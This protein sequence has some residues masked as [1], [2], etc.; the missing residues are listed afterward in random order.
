MMV[1][2]LGGGMVSFS[3]AVVICIVPDFVD[4]DMVMVVY[5]V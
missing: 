4:D 1:T 2:T 5:E 3:C